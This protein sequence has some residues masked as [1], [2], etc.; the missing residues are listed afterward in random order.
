MSD[1]FSSLASQA[2]QFA[3]SIADSIATQAAEAQHQLEEAQHQLEAEQRKIR[4][5]EDLKNQKMH[6]LSSL[7]WETDD[8]SL[9]I[10]S[11]DLMEQIFL[12]SV[13][14]DNFTTTASNS[15]DVYFNLK[16]FVPA[17][18]N[19]LKL[20]S[21]LARVH[22]KLSPKMDEEE[23]W[24]NYFCRVVYLRDSIGMNGPEAKQASAKYKRNEIIMETKAVPSVK[25]E[26]PN[27]SADATKKDSSG[28]SSG[29]SSA[30]ISSKQQKQQQQQRERGSPSSQASSSNSS[31]GNNVGNSRKGTLLKSEEEELL[32]AEIHAALSSSTPGK[33]ERGGGGGSGEGGE[34][35]LDQIDLDENE[36]MLGDDVDIDLGDLEDLLD[37][38]ESVDFEQI[39]KSECTETVD[40]IETDALE[41]QIAR[42]LAMQGS[43]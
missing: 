9:A 31:V 24:F 17:A 5:E 32:A 34:E 4:E 20:D 12:L 41:A 13:N 18:M 43:S 23:F 37:V 33:S 35:S 28:A 14:E 2:M 19:L 38:E 21:N 11:Q 29:R 27:P 40:D 3:D 15:K 16:D 26:I 42:E 1:W 22:A 36:L 30:N 10:L 6:T 39:G 8:E 7:P 25:K